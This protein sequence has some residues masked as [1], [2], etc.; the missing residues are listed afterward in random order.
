MVD[1]G[2]NGASATGGL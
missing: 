1:L 2:R